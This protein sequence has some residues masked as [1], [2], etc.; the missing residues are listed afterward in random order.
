[1]EVGEHAHLEESQ[2]H[3]ARA[4]DGAAFGL[5]FDAHKD[6]VF[7]HAYRI[8]LSRHD[9]EDASAI[10]FLELWR[11]RSTV[12]IVNG[13]VLPWLVVTTTNACRNLER[14]R[15]RY[16]RLLESL[17]HSIDRASAE[18]DAL[19]GL[20]LGDDLVSALASLSPTDA[21]LFALVA[22]EGYTVADAARTVGVTPGAARVRMHRARSALQSRLGHRTLTEYLSKEMS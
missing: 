22:L 2:W 19:R 18:D 7:R 5:I 8:L 20:G 10:A 15:R 1:M 14:G 13:S 6:R 12:R 4:G 17:P 16:R 3:L 21:Q 11:R 9:A